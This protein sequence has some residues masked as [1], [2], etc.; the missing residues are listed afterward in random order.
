MGFTLAAHSLQALSRSSIV[1]STLVRG[2]ESENTVKTFLKRV[3]MRFSIHLPMR[4]SIQGF[5]TRQKMPIM[6]K[7]FLK[8]IISTLFFD[9][10]MI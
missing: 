7:Y 1:K 2:K 10:F 3:L 9:I 6:Q 5:L 4:F 8:S